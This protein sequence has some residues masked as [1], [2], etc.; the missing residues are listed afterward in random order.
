MGF[1]RL[2]V[3]TLFYIYRLTFSAIRQRRVHL[4][5]ATV[6]VGYLIVLLYI[7]I[8]ATQ[9][10]MTTTTSSR[11]IDSN[12]QQSQTTKQRKSIL[13]KHAKYQKKIQ[14]SSKKGKRSDKSLQNAV[15][16]PPPRNF[17]EPS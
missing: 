11:I 9:P 14:T 7:Q 1:R 6:L 5:I 17:T 3:A 16:I 15:K 8:I 2:I 12:K 13:N 10:D 4:F